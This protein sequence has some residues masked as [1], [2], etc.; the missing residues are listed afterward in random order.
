MFLRR[1]LAFCQQC[2]LLQR[3]LRVL[4]FRAEHPPCAMS[5]TSFLVLLVA[6]AGTARAGFVPVV[7]SG[8]SC[9]P[10]KDARAIQR[11]KSAEQRA[12]T[13]AE[14]AKRQVSMLRRR[15]LL[16]RPWDEIPNDPS[17]PSIMSILDIHDCACQELIKEV[18]SWMPTNAPRG[19]RLRRTVRLITQNSLA[20]EASMREVRAPRILKRR[21][22][23]SESLAVEAQAQLKRAYQ[24]SLP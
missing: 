23:L 1:T 14:I 5:T 10:T 9:L 12:E 3:I 8:G 13:Y 15:L 20:L 2:G 11:S 22:E 17:G 4:C 19:E 16:S 7:P 18:M 21:I 24:D 6:T